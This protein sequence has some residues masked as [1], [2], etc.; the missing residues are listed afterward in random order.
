MAYFGTEE[1]A[2]IIVYVVEVQFPINTLVNILEELEDILSEEESDISEDE[3]G[4]EEELGSSDDDA[5]EEEDF[6]VEEL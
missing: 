2:L 4:E 1:N 6:T 3:L 5:G